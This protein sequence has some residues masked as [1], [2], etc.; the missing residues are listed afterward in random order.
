MIKRKSLNNSAGVPGSPD[1]PGS[2]LK[3]QKS[4]IDEYDDSMPIWFPESLA[5]EA[6][7]YLTEEKGRLFFRKNKQVLYYSNKKGIIKPITD[8]EKFLRDHV[9]K[10][11]RGQVSADAGSEFKELLLSDKDQRWCKPLPERDPG[12]VVF[13]GKYWIDLKKKFKGH[14]GCEMVPGF[15]RRVVR[16][17]FSLP[18]KTIE[19]TDEGLLT[20]GQVVSGYVLDASVFWCDPDTGAVL[21]EILNTAY[22]DEG[23]IAHLNAA[24]GMKDF[25]K[26]GKDDSVSVCL[27][28]LT[29]EGWK[30]RV[31]NRLN[32]LAE[33][34]KPVVVS[35]DFLPFVPEGEIGSELLEKSISVIKPISAPVGNDTGQ[36][37]CD[38]LW[39]LNWVIRH[40]LT[41]LKSS[42]GR[43]ASEVGSIDPNDRAAMLEK[44]VREKMQKTG[45]GDNLI[46]QD[47]I[48]PRFQKFVNDAGG[49]GYKINSTSLGRRLKEV[50]GQDQD[51]RPRPGD[52]KY[53]S[54]LIGYVW[55][56]EE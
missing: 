28:G 49:D 50:A 26:A 16:V 7:D 37:I 36:Y 56:D 19:Q 29:K 14:T 18:S 12:Y 52:G 47:E 41:G 32:R 38:S 23:A 6:A 10:T 27:H 33:S 5:R 51:D 35:A 55:S 11:M 30:P 17:V 46:F 54:A 21:G 15:Q 2:G 20:V 13:P 45:N 1:Y 42:A 34:K 25:E 53:R 48:L 4:R 40:N 39:M 9:K 24:D 43:V 22:P 3:K 8:Y 31:R 44:F